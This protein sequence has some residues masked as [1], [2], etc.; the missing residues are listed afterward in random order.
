MCVGRAMARPIQNHSNFYET[1][2]SGNYELAVSH[3]TPND[4]HHPDWT[5]KQRRKKMQISAEFE[6]YD[7]LPKLH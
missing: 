7:T 1:L 5:V 4:M 6:T 2:K 3:F